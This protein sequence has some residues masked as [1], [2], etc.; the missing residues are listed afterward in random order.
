MY[1]K[2]KAYS[3]NTAIRNISVTVC[4]TNIVRARIVYN[5]ITLVKDSKSGV[6][7]PNHVISGTN[8]FRGYGTNC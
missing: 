6:Y 3:T 5:Y 2:A 4:E 1:V 8:W 7:D